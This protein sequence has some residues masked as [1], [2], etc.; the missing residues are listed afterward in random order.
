MRGRGLFS[1]NL[2]LRHDREF[3]KSNAH[4]FAFKMASNAATLS[5]VTLLVQAALA[6]LPRGIVATSCQLSQ[7][8]QKMDAFLS[9]N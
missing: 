6:A 9:V 3:G 7:F 1:E 5:G 4:H 2:F 8:P